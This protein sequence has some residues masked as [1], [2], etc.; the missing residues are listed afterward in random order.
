MI[1]IRK[2]F[3]VS[4]SCFSKGK[5]VREI[6]DAVN[7]ELRPEKLLNRESVYPLLAMGAI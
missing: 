3:F 2:S 5:T 4:L 7:K 6:A 1:Q